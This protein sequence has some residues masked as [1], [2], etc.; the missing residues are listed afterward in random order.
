[1]A[2][3]NALGIDVLIASPVVSACTT[4]SDSLTPRGAMYYGFTPLASLVKTAPHED[5]GE[6]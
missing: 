2:D 4:M 1:M 3:L 6:L 5:T